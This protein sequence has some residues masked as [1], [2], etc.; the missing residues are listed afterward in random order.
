MALDGG[1]ERVDRLD[2]AADRGREAD[3]IVGA[4]AVVIHPLGHGNDGPAPRRELG[5]KAQRPVASPGHHS[6]D[7]DRL[8]HI[9]EARRAVAP[10]DGART[11]TGGLEAG[12][13]RKSTLYGKSGVD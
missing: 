4:E 3:A 2:R 12:P 7:D 11:R 6:I 1:P 5:R 8:Q 13:A 9:T 10:A